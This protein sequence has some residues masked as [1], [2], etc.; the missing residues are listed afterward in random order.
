MCLKA[1]VDGLEATNGN[2]FSVREHRLVGVIHNIVTEPAGMLRSLD[3]I[4][5]L[6]FD[7]PV[8]GP[9]WTEHQHLSLLSRR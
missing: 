9:V 6:E 4:A 7:E 2:L 5:T 3:W 8:T 1:S